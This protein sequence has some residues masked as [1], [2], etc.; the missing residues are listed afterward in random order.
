MAKRIIK[1]N[2]VKDDVSKKT[3]NEELNNKNSKSVNENEKNIIRKPKSKKTTNKK[4]IK[5]QVSP[6][7][8]Q[9]VE[10]K[11]EQKSSTPSVKPEEKKEV[12]LILKSELEK[13][14]ESK[15]QPSK[16]EEPKQPLPKKKAKAPRKKQVSPKPE[17]KLEQKPE[18]KSSTPSVKAEEKK[19]VKLI[20][21]SELE[22]TNESKP[23]PSKAEEPKKINNLSTNQTSNKVHQKN[24]SNTKNNHNK[25]NQN[26][27]SENYSRPIVKEKKEVKP[28]IPALPLNQEFLIPTLKRRDSYFKNLFKSIN[29]FLV[30]DLYLDNDLKIVIGVSGGCDSV[31]L[32]DILANLSIENKYQLYIA[33]YDHSLRKES[34]KDM[35]YVRDLAKKYNVK[36]FTKKENVKDYANKKSMSVEEAARVLRYEFFEEITE[37]VE[38]S[39]LALA[40]NAND[41]AE[42]FFINLFRG[43]GL[44]GLSGIPQKR[45]LNKDV[46]IIRPIINLS[47]KEVEEYASKRELIWV[48]D[49][50][51]KMNIYLRN[52]IRNELL[53]FIQETFD[54][55]IVNSVNKTS[56]LI[57]A[58]DVFIYHKVKKYVT[59]V[60]IEKKTSYIEIDLRKLFLYDDFVKAEIVGLILKNNFEFINVTQNILK[61]ILNLYYLEPGANFPIND[62]LIAY[63][64]RD[65]IFIARNQ[66]FRDKSVTIDIIGEFR[67]ENKIFK[68]SKV[69]KTK[70]NYDDAPNIEYFD[71]DYMPDKLEIRHIKDG[72]KFTPLGMTGR[73]KVNDYLTNNKIPLLKKKDILV[74]TDRVNIIWLCE[75]RIADKYKI[76][77]LTKKVLKIEILEK[78]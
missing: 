18:Q 16:A 24:V 5:K 6:K 50:T 41:S 27:N 48:E 19:E 54:K 42:T 58:A 49:I 4:V 72:D 66:L 78:K 70:I 43:T 8:E 62:K 22:K 11:P 10:Q 76:N 44:S 71:M 1:E 31:V 39:F 33:H 46:T 60:I 35:E 51:N 67:F 61:N 25:S 13:T 30:K 77:P 29:D 28:K 56:K 12:K 73:M 7:P 17:Q 75:H 59:D 74:L 20:L 15:P 57:N 26:K 3:L 47:R 34:F 38:A 45:P 52:K 40:H 21:K 53:P 9:K 69:P 2:E 68:L 32:F 64:D 23:Q 63:K 55:D 37:K 65:T 14:N 36:F